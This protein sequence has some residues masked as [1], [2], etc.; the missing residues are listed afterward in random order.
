MIRKSTFLFYVLCITSMHMQGADIN[1]QE[2]EQIDNSGIWGTAAHSV[3]GIL[4]AVSTSAA[5]GAK[6]YQG[7]Q[8][9]YQHP[10]TTAVLGCAGTYGLY[11]ASHSTPVRFARNT[12]LITA[13]A[14]VAYRTLVADEEIKDLIVTGCNTVLSELHAIEGRLTHLIAGADQRNQEGQRALA[15]RLERLESLV[16]SSSSQ[17]N[18]DILDEPVQKLES[19]LPDNPKAIQKNPGLLRG[20]WDWFTSPCTN[21]FDPDQNAATFI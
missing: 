15:A 12:T 18:H 7:A 14:L 6:L 9:V 10:K 8:W 4:G 5:I 1:I 20:A 3:Q 16:G 17:R 19:N 2:A 21:E 13:G 11:R